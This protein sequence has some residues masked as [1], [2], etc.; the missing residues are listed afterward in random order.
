MFWLTVA[1]E[2]VH[3]QEIQVP[4]EADAADCVEKA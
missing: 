2:Q 4:K 1:I 3:A